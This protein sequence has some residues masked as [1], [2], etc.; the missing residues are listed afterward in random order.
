MCVCLPVPRGLTVSDLTLHVCESPA[1]A[2]SSHRWRRAQSWRSSRPM[3][4]KRGITVDHNG[5]IAPHKPRGAKQRTQKRA[6]CWHG[7][8]NSIFL[9]E[10]VAVLVAVA[11]QDT[12]NT[13]RQKEVPEPPRHQRANLASLPGGRC[14]PVGCG[15]L[16]VP[17]NALP[18]G[19]FFFSRDTVVVKLCFCK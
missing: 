14:L 9:S 15:S 6:G 2:L 10:T 17:L 3:A 7:W 8:G 5:F 11:D 12:D 18:F 19:P 13:D 1:V 4:W 16:H